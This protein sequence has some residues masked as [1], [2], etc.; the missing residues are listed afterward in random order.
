MSTSVNSTLD[1]FHD[2]VVAGEVIKR[3]FCCWAVP[4]KNNYQTSRFRTAKVLHTKWDV[5]V[6]LFF[7]VL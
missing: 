4:V 6:L 2:V 5:L 1:L 3:L 7:R